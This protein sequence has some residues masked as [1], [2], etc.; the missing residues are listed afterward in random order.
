MGRKNSAPGKSFSSL[1]K[2]L[3]RSEIFVTSSAD[4]ADIERETN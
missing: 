3:V 4:E 1:N 2:S